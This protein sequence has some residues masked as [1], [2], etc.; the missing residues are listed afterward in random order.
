MAGSETARALTL[1]CAFIPPR[2]STAVDLQ[3]PDVWGVWREVVSGALLTS[4]VMILGDL[5]ART[6]TL[7]DFVSES[8]TSF[9]G[10]PPIGTPR[11]SMGVVSSGCDNAHGRA[12]LALCRGTGMRIVK[13]RTSGDQHGDVT[14]QSMQGPSVILLCGRLPVLDGGDSFSSRSSGWRV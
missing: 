4:N 1:V 7:P 5:N 13:V 3:R 11:R 12:L 2:G 14:V 9:H 8:P 6:G 10:P